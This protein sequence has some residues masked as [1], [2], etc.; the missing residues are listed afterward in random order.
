MAR[1]RKPRHDQRPDDES[2]ILAYCVF[3]LRSILDRRRQKHLVGRR[4]GRAIHDH[5]RP[6][7]PV[8]RLGRQRN[9]NRVGRLVADNARLQP[10]ENDVIR[11]AI[12]RLP[13]CGYGSRDPSCFY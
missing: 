11:V 4:L 7:H 10:A 6:D 1:G 2:A 12:V 13:V 3:E 9:H 8:R 5:E